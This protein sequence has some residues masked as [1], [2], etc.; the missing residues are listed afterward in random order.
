MQT[1]F[2]QDTPVQTQPVTAPV[3]AAASGW[4]QCN[5]ADRYTVD[6][7]IGSDGKTILRDVTGIEDFGTSS[8][9]EVVQ[10]KRRGNGD[11]IIVCKITYNGV[12]F[13]D[14]EV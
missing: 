2:A 3:S 8:V 4:T 11:P 5:T 9:T 7:N 14:V 10:I 6:N 12:T 13:D 1:T